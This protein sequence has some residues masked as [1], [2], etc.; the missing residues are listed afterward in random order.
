[1]ETSHAK[2]PGFRYRCVP[3]G[4]GFKPVPGLRTGPGDPGLLFENE[5][6]AD[7]GGVCL[8]WQGCGRPILDHH[9]HRAGQ[10]PSAAAAVLHQAHRIAAYFRPFLAGADAVPAIWLATHADPDFDA[11]CSLFLAR[12]LLAGEIQAQ[13]WDRLGLHPEGW[14]DVAVPE[15][16]EPWKIDWFEPFVA[17]LP[18]EQRWPILLA[19]YASRVDNSKPLSCLRQSALHAVLYAAKVRQRPLPDGAEAFFQ[20]ARELM[21]GP[22]ALNPLTDALFDAASPYAPELEL[23]AAEQ[24]RYQRDVRRARI[25]IVSLPCHDDFEA[26]FEAASQAPLHDAAGGLAPLH[27]QCGWQSARQADG[28]YLRDPESILFKEWARMDTGNSPSQQGFLFTAVVYSTGAGGRPRCVFSLDPER[29]Q[30]AHLYP[31]WARLQA[32]E[33]S[34]RKARG[35]PEG[36]SRKGFEGRRCGADPWFDGANY[37]C[38]ILDAP[39]QGTLLATGSR[40]DLRDDPAVKI[41]SD[42]LEYGWF[43]DE[44]ATI[45]DFPTDP[46][47]LAPGRPAASVLPKRVAINK[48]EA[49]SPPKNVF[50]FAAIPLREGEDC[51][52]RNEHLRRQTGE[53]LWL[54]LEDQNVVT[55]PVDFREH[56]LLGGEQM[57]LVWGRRG[58]A[59]ACQA[60]AAGQAGQL[61]E[62]AECWARVAAGFQ[63]LLRDRAAGQTQ[64]SQ[65]QEG[66]ELLQLLLTLKH[67]SSLPEGKVLRRLFEAT[68]MDDL[69][70]AIQ[71]FNQQDLE[72]IREEGEKRRDVTL[73]VI[74]AVGTGLGLWLGWN[75]M[76]GMK[77]EQ[78][79]GN[80]DWALKWGGAWLGLLFIG[81]YC[82]ISKPWRN[83]L[84]KTAGAKPRP[85]PP[86]L[87][88]GAARDSQPPPAAAS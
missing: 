22:R 9:F 52:L 35:M 56:H 49:D 76:E 15:G 59:V 57:V 25:A 51:Y 48:A 71:E 55:V 74:L 1:M 20:A 34:E 16:R 77:F 2:A 8:G 32:A 81:L 26:W 39:H 44:S 41:V 70:S 4:T 10:Y 23:L 21:A 68:H 50:R 31:A 5:L 78:L 6:A 3:Y 75:Q 14:E 88:G 24:E 61:R 64:E 83:W 7:V 67:R 42:L 13:G 18:P 37:E 33:M 12:A 85:Q 69:V 72:G 17:H 58:I 27:E 80:W 28:I 65:I 84:D 87:G 19:A 63:K 43:A 86:E 73:Q 62:N 47:P 45:H 66:K 79:G 53:I 11:L 36:E 40:S 30:G 60:A 29:A 46:A 82:A 54:L 38:T